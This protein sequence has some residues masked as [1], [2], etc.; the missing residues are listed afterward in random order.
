MTIFSGKYWVSYYYLLIMKFVTKLLLAN[1]RTLNVQS[2]ARACVTDVTIKRDR[3]WVGSTRIESPSV[4]T[5]RVVFSAS[6]RH[7]I[8]TGFCRKSWKSVLKSS[9]WTSSLSPW[10]IHIVRV[11][12]HWYAVSVC[13]CF[14]LAPILP[15]TRWSWSHKSE[16]KFAVRTKFESSENTLTLLKWFEG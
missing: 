16:A 12:T 8:T 5:T 15:W 1:A 7:I 13:I 4:R 3:H 14:C 11:G 6:D 10:D 2:K 9:R